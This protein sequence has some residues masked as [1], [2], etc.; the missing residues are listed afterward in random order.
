M[1]FVRLFNLRSFGFICFFFPL[2]SGTS[3]GGGD[4]ACNC[5]TP[6]TFLFPFSLFYEAICFKSCLLCYF[7][8]FLCFSPFSMRL[9]RFGKR[10][11]K[12]VLFVRLFNLPLFVYVYFLFLLMPGK[13]CG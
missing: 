10:E 6:W 5:D 3:G 2:V 13:G 8:L 4:V 1:L 9:T 11:Q 12:L 7:I